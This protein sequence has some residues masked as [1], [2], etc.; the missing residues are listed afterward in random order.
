MMDSVTRIM[1]CRVTD[2]TFLVYIKYYVTFTA[3]LTSTLAPLDSS[4]IRLRISAIVVTK[5]CDIRL[6]FNNYC[7]CISSLSL[8]LMRSRAA[9]EQVPWC[10][11]SVASKMASRVMCRQLGVVLYSGNYSLARSLRLQEKVGTITR[12]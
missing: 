10:E 7:K 4:G 9:W 2:H 12:V 6:K 11:I 5:L 8:R 3:K 1:H